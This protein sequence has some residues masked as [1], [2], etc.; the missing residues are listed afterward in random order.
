MKGYEKYT[1]DY[2][3]LPYDPDEW[4]P[5]IQNYSPDFGVFVAH[6]KITRRLWA[7]RII[8]RVKVALGSSIIRDDWLANSQKKFFKPSQCQS[9]SYNQLCDGLKCGY[10]QLYPDYKVYP[11]AGKVLE[12]PM[13]V[14]GPY[15]NS[16][17]VK[18]P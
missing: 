10:D 4:A 12:D 13:A 18:I 11:F 17:D 6:D 9:C 2:P 5:E 7:Q 14:R 16:L 1:C 15:L 3:Q 8:A